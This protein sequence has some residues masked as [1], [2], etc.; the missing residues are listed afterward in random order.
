MKVIEYV[1][2]SEYDEN[3]KFLKTEQVIH[4]TNCK[5][6]KEAKQ[7]LRSKEY[8]RWRSDDEFYYKRDTMV[9]SD[10]HKLMWF[11]EATLG[12]QVPI[13]LSSR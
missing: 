4:R 10:G 6:K 3:W 2:I 11:Y 1:H 5:N 13:C 9:L 7:C 12:T 8:E